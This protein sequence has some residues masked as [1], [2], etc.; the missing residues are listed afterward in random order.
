MYNICLLTLMF[1]FLLSVSMTTKMS[2][3]HIICERIFIRVL[4]FN[5]FFKLFSFFNKKK[6]RK[7]LLN[8]ENSKR[9]KKI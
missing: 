3:M 8:L 9:V 1:V 7:I 4:E 5:I 6:K 2:E